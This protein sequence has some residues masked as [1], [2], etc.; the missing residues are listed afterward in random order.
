MT[1]TTIRKLSFLDRFLTLWIFLAMFVGVGSGYLF[2]KIKN[3]INR[4]SVVTTNIPI[5]VGLILI[6][7]VSLTPAK[8][9]ADD[10]LNAAIPQQVPT[11]GQVT[12][13]DLGANKCIPCKMMAPILKELKEEYAG[14]ASIVFIDVWEN[15]EQAQRFGIRTIPTQIFY[16]KSG[17][18]VQRHVGFLDKKSIV[19]TFEKLG[20]P[21]KTEN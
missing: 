2:P 16:D 19:A 6:I 17:R 18:E 8:T 10:L 12:M 3:F 4:F 15:R 20:V 14:R 11:K 5:A 1:D 21:K 13:V 9:S 7:I